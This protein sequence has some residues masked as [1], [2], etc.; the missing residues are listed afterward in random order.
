M[1]PAGD[2]G[3]DH[4]EPSPETDL[5]ELLAALHTHLAETGERPV[6]RE[7]ARWLGEAEAVA[8]DVADGDAPAGAIET[9]V[10]QVREL[11]AHVDATGDEVADKHV[12][13]VRQL[14]DAIEDQL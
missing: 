14:A 12:E 11:V 13:A 5:T 3:P 6:G 4:V 2:D 9:R 7:A 1:A 10:E 8:A